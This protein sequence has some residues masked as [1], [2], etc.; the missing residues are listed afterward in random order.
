MVNKLWNS[1]GA[2][3]S[4]PRALSYQGTGPHN[5]F[6]GLNIVLR[7]VRGGKAF[8]FCLEV[9]RR[10]DLIPQISRSAVVN[11]FKRIQNDL[12][13]SQVLSMSS[14]HFALRDDAVVRMVG[15]CRYCER[16]RTRRSGRD[17]SIS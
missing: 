11:A 2:G 16:V 4:E 15:Q 13:T 8:D 5:G 9:F 7:T 6:N 3:F 17:L 10:Y 12:V 14:K 1:A